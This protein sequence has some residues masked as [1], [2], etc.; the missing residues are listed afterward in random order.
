M[1]NN[2]N[3]INE[4]TYVSQ[5]LN[6]LNLDLAYMLSKA[7]GHEAEDLEAILSSIK[8]ANNG[9]KE[10]MVSLD[11]NDSPNTSNID[12]PSNQSNEAWCD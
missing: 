8:Q 3:K 4:L 12:L 5:R 6:S 2:S 1:S 7:S 10:L 9:V 11:K